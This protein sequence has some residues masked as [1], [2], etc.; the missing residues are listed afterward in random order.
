MFTC[1]KIL[2]L[3]SLLFGALV[4]P[5]D[6]YSPLNFKFFIILVCLLFIG[7]KGY[8]NHSGAYVYSRSTI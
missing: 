1:A 3:V 6:P 7:H 2:F 5:F 8:N 4:D